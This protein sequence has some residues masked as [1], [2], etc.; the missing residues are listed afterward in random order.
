MKQIK[1]VKQRK[2]SIIEKY[3]QFRQDLETEV[4]QRD[5]RYPPL[6][7][8][9]I[10]NELQAMKV[11]EIKGVKYDEAI[12]K[13]AV[14]LHYI[15]PKAYEFLREQLTL[16]HK[17]T[18]ASMKSRVVNNEIPTPAPLPAE[19]NLRIGSDSDSSISS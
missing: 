11:K 16:P 4:E 5:S 7:R 2:I 3:K 10:G 9:L 19:D 12:Q 17:S 15:S 18:I 8:A 1:R 14:K 6:I 13:F